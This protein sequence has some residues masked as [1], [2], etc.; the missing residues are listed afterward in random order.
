MHKLTKRKLRK[1]SKRENKARKGREIR[2]AQRKADPPSAARK[3]VVL[4]LSN[5]FTFK[6]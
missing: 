2:R 5:S 6:H 3:I 1:V 4:G